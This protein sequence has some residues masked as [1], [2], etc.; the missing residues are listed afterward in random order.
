MH[1]KK[2][3]TFLPEAFFSPQLVFHFF[4]FKISRINAF[5]VIFSTCKPYPLKFS[6]KYTYIIYVL[7][8]ILPQPSPSGPP[9]LFQGEEPGVR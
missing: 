2:L 6:H 5:A 7:N 1:E 8:K 3:R 4:L 9:L